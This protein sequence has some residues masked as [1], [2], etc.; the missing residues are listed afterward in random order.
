MSFKNNAESELN[1]S[2]TQWKY[3]KRMLICKDIYNV[4]PISKLQSKALFK[5]YKDALFIRYTT[6]IDSTES[7][8]W[9][10]CIKDDKY[11]FEELKSKRKNV[12]RKGI[13][14]FSV[15]EIKLSEHI[16]D[17]YTLINDAYAGYDIVQTV[18]YEQAAKKARSISEGKNYFVLGAFPNGSDRLVGYLWC[19]V[20]G[21]CIS[22]SEQKTVREFEHDGVNAALLYA[23][24]E[25]YNQEFADLGYYLFDGWKNILH[26]T[27]FQDYL[28]KYF[29]FRRAYSNLHIIYNPKYAW[30]FRPALFVF[31]IYGFALRKISPGAYGNIEAIRKIQKLARTA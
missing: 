9:Y 6:D 10:C 21:K 27:N 8:D 7:T 16:D 19:H 22:M 29:G 23:L 30:W 2:A 18:S 24:C 3:R 25:K 17:F 1:I 4:N 28:I 14:N 31:P 13:S 5:K 11:D 15:R 12:V 20:D 26:R